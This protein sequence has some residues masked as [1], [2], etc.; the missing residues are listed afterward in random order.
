MRCALSLRRS[1]QALNLA[2]FGRWT[3]RNEAAQRR[4]A[5]RYAQKDMTIPTTRL[6]KS[7]EA[8]VRD[9]SRHRLHWP[10]Y[11]DSGWPDYGDS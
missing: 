6:R 11:A 4:L 10:I 2:P 1:N 9:P 7:L 3:L 8:S 5:L